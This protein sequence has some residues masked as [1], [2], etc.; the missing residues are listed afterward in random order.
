MLIYWDIKLHWVS[1]V[2]NST[3]FL[4]VCPSQTEYGMRL[5]DHQLKHV[6]DLRGL[7][8]WP[9]SLRL[10]HW[11][12]PRPESD[13]NQYLLLGAHAYSHDSKSKLFQC[14]YVVSQSTDSQRTK[15]M[16]SAVGIRCEPCHIY[17]CDVQK[18]TR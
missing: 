3:I 4:Q 6:S 7:F 14:L 5:L 1:R 15:L 9:V 8:F 18:L 12:I 10:A 13:I 16:K 2:R 17:P 11:Q